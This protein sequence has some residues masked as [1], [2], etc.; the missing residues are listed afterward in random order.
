MEC[1]VCHQLKFAMQKPE[2]GKFSRGAWQCPNGCKLED[3]LRWEE[4]AQWLKKVSEGYSADE[5]NVM[6]IRLMDMLCYFGNSY[7]IYEFQKDIEDK[8][9]E[10]RKR[11]A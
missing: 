3:A 7:L 4:W 11:T 8:N 6:I 5:Y 1:K 2:V 10:K 9:G